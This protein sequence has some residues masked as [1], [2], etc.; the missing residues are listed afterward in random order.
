MRRGGATPFSR[1][2]KSAFGF[3]AIGSP[4]DERLMLLEIASKLQARP[5]SNIVYR[6]ALDQVAGEIVKLASARA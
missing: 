6:Q 1:D 4:E 2:L 5:V 3:E